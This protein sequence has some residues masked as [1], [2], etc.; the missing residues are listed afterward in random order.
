MNG[1]LFQFYFSNN[2]TSGH[3]K[4]CEFDETH[5]FKKNGNIKN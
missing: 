5:L 4:G 2:V 3:D 1:V